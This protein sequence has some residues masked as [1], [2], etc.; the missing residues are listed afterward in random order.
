MQGD[1]CLRSVCQRQEV[2]GDGCQRRKMVSVHQLIIEI[3]L[4]YD[5][6]RRI[7]E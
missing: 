2:Q 1:T 6:K 4:L 3:H 7:K 5:V